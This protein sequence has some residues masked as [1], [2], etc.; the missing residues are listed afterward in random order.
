MHIQLVETQAAS[1]EPAA[2]DTSV[3]TETVNFFEMGDVS[4]ET[5]GTLHG[6]EWNWTPHS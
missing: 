2:T 6:I 4:T 3:P 5:K 1:K